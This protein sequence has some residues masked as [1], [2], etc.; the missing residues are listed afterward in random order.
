MTEQERL[1]DHAE[2][3]KSLG[4]AGWGMMR[5]LQFSNLF[6]LLRSLKGFLCNERIYAFQEEHVEEEDG[7]GWTDRAAAAYRHLK[8]T[9]R[10]SLPAC[11][12]S[13]FHQSFSSRC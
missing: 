2:A 1:R 4:G 13:L 12:C 9:K 6:V 8:S 5:G 3:L 10:E 7:G 11:R